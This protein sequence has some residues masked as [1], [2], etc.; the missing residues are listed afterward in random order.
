[1]DEFEQ[2]LHDELGAAGRD[3][4]ASDSLGVAVRRR[5]RRRQTFASA[6]AALPVV[7]L[8]VGA[9]WLLDTDDE[10]TD[11]D[12]VDTTP[13]TSTT[14][15]SP[16][17]EDPLRQA[18]IALGAAV[19]TAPIEAV[20]LGG[21]EWCGVDEISGL[22]GEL[23]DDAPGDCLIDATEAGRDAAMVR[24]EITIEGDPIVTVA[25]TRSALFEA[26]I[27][28][29]SSQDAFGRPGWTE[30]RC[31]LTVDESAPVLLTWQNC[32][33]PGTDRLRNALLELGVALASAPEEAV[34]P[35]EGTWCGVVD[36]P[37]P[38][39]RR[40]M[41]E[42][43]QSRSPAAGVVLITTT[44]GDPIVEVHRMEP[45]GYIVRWVD[46]TRD[47]FGSRQWE[48]PWYCSEFDVVDGDPVGANN[49]DSEPPGGSAPNEAE[50]DE[51]PTDV[52]EPPPYGPGV[53]VGQSYDYSLYT[54]C[55]IEWAQIDG[56]WWQT[57]APLDDGNANPPPGW[58]NPFDTGVLEIVD[59]T[60]AV[61]RG[62]PDSEVEFSRTEVAESP[63]SDCD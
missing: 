44:E 14:S 6:L 55:G 56:A 20:T 4:G 9:L 24:V 5:V 1:M 30:L 41:W 47:N 50:T 19:D 34:A 22:T 54:H 37:N 53:E 3:V 60:T 57:P 7:L 8:A 63:L 15:P 46:A 43:W 35:V 38:E 59:E 12:V 29:D 36:G 18:L 28:I 45:E 25:W 13:P 58:G 33:D 21:A 49:C 31:N 17:V 52:V 61:Y 48:G 51:A 40:C 2:R 10:A 26:P 23:D 27:Y 16:T 39:A 11:V 62:G 32:I 42:A